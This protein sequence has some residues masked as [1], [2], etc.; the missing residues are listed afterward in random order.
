MAAGTPQVQDLARYGA[1]RTRSAS[2]D[3]LAPRAHKCQATDRQ[4]AGSRHRERGTR[5]QAWRSPRVFGAGFHGERSPGSPPSRQWIGRCDVA[6]RTTTS[7]LV[8]MRLDLAEG[9][10]NRLLYAQIFISG[11]AVMAKSAPTPPRTWAYS[12][13][14]VA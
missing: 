6:K 7:A 13:Q 12:R 9:R 11:K 8:V 2:M 1:H 14:Y 3:R 5:A 4:P 10:L